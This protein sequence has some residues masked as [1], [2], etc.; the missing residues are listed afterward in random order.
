MLKQFKKIFN[1]AQSSADTKEPEMAKED[2]TQADKSVVELAAELTAVQATLASQAEA[3]KTTAEQ[4]AALTAE[5]DVAI[6]ALAASEAAKQKMAADAL[7]MK[8]SARTEK[9][10]AAIG[11][12][13]APA[14]V[15]ATKDLDDS[16]F[17]SVVSALA[18]SV[19]DESKSSMFTEAGHNGKADNQATDEEE[20]P[21]AKI[22]KS[23]YI[24]TK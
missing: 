24:K 19:A 22:L 7:T 20:S 14:L 2:G 12:E 10:V 8:M 9:V 13:K 18:G 17:A 3:M 21:E 1:K 16:A 11:T 15:A 6:A 5:R 4:L 23:K